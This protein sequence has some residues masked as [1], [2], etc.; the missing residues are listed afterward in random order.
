[1]KKYKKN[2]GNTKLLTKGT[3]IER[4]AI[5]TILLGLL[6]ILAIEIYFITFI[7]NITSFDIFINI[8]LAVVVFFICTAYVLRELEKTNEKLNE[9]KVKLERLVHQKDEFIH[10]LGHDIKNPLQPLLTL[11]PIAIDDAENSKVKE[12]LGVCYRNVQSI[13]EILLRTLE[14]VKNEDMQNQLKLDDL[15]LKSFVDDCASDMTALISK[16]NISF[17]NLIPENIIVKADRVRLKEIF[18]NLIS[19]SIKYSN[20]DGG[21][22]KVDAIRLDDKY[23][24]IMVKDDGIGIDKE[25]LINIFDKFNPST[26]LAKNMESHGLGL[27]I[28]KNIVQQHSGEIWVESQGFGKGTTIYFTLPKA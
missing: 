22:I 19:N 6:I 10:I 21:F 1:M 27:S 11:L 17:H 25:K 5:K 7:N 8:S 16:N 4:I 24:R 28:V 18:H 2:D 13:L 9:A 3:G 14:Q 12:M 23:A 15:D 26:D 20:D